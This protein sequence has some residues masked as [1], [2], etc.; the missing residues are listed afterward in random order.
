GGGED[1]VE[2]PARLPR[3]ERA[4]DHL[5]AC[6]LGEIRPCRGGQR[7]AE[8]DARDREPAAREWQRGLAGRAADLQQPVAGTQ[9][10]LPDERVEQLVRILGPGVLIAAGGGVERVPQTHFT[11]SDAG[12]ARRRPRW[13][14]SWRRSAAG[15]RPG[16]TRGP[17]SRGRRRAR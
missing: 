4:L 17:A 7:R 15:R 6:E 10:G 8:F 11:E 14:R 1:E 9:A 13:S 3:L 5:D 16:R 12:A 2:A